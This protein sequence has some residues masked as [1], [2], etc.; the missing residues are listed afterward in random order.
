MTREQAHRLVAQGAARW[1]SE[2][3]VEIFASRPLWRY[4]LRSRPGNH[5]V[6]PGGPS[7]VRF[8]GKPVHR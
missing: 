6:D 7:I 3:E 4:A 1:L 5:I 2:N 8:L